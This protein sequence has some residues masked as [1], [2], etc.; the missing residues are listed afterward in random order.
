MRR[1]CALAVLCAAVPALAADGGPAAAPAAVD[2]A[3]AALL[4]RLD[5]QSRGVTDLSG[6]FTQNNRIKIFKQEVRSKGRFYFQR[7]RRIRWEYLEPDPSTLVLDGNLATL[8]SP[9]APAQT[10]DLAR[11]AVMRTVFDQLLLW[12][13]SESLSRAEADYDLVAGGTADAPSLTLTPKARSPIARAFARIDLRFD[14]KLLLSSILLREPGG[15]EKEIRFTKM[16][17]NAK[18][19]PGAFK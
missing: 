1:L 5:A 14:K 18:L 8:R 6:E 16:E 3:V 12:L 19:P 15:D 7:P 11:D 17:Q 10:F 2:P 13:G 4:K 9:G